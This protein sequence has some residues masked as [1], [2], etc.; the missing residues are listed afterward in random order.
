MTGWK[1]PST[2]RPRRHAALALGFGSPEA[3]AAAK[4]PDSTF[5]SLLCSD[6]A[7]R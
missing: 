2:G 7:P 1:L 3:L 4:M 5:G 6:G